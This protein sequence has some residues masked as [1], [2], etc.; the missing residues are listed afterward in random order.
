MKSKI[1]KNIEF[2][3]YN[4]KVDNNE[5]ENI[6]KLSENKIVLDKKNKKKDK[7]GKIGNIENSKNG[8]IDGNRSKPISSFYNS[9]VSL[10]NIS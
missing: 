8:F 1:E 5:S 2:D 6:F 3:N 7:N 4:K 10:C 9:D